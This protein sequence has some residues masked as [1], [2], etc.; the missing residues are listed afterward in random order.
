[1]LKG[2]MKYSF[3]GVNT[4]SYVLCLDLV[5]VQKPFLKEFLAGIL[6]FL[7]ILQKLLFFKDNLCL[8]SRNLG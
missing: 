4:E 6:D 2:S 7:Q 8:L 3:Q 1:M 5:Y